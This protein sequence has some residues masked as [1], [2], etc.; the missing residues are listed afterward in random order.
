MVA[1]SGSTSPRP[2]L[3]ATAGHFLSSGAVLSRPVSV[4]LSGPPKSAT[5]GS[6]EA[7]GAPQ[8]AAQAIARRLAPAKP[9]RACSRCGEPATSSRHHYCDA[10]RAQAKDRRTH[11]HRHRDRERT[12]TRPTTT[13]QGYGAAHQKLRAKWAPAVAGGGVFCARCGGRID[14]GE[15][16]DLGHDDEDRSRYAGPEQ[17]L[18]NRRTATHRAD[19]RRASDSRSWSRHWFGGYDA[20][21]PDCRDGV[22]CDAAAAEPAEGCFLGGVRPVHLATPLCKTD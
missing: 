18:C 22:P 6:L 16:W 9:P 7:R 13:E 11:E 20:R 14:P 1:G 15:P 12:A 17:S 8:T 3:V 10:C 2:A 5:G 19:R 4:S 21:C